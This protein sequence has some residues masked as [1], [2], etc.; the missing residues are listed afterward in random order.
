MPDN[1]LSAIVT[2]ASGQLGRS[3]KDRVPDGV[4]LHMFSRDEF[5][6]SDPVHIDRVFKQYDFDFLINCAAFTGVDLAESIPQEAYRI[7]A[8]AV[9]HLADACRHYDKTLIHISSDYVYDNDITRPLIE[10][11]RTEPKSVYAKSKLEGDR[12][13]VENCPKAIVLRTSW[14][15][16]EYGK[17]FANTMLRLGRERQE[18]RVVADQHGIPTYASDLA[19]AIY[20]IIQSEPGSF[21][22]GIYHFSNTGATTW[23]DF[24]GEILRKSGL[25]TSV[26][27]IDTT[28]FPTPASRPMYSVLDPTKFSKQFSFEIRHWH[29]ALDACLTQI[30]LKSNTDN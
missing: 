18:L 17:N 19:N 27:P 4:T 16:S 30:A 26:V 24:A 21:D 14:L 6:I 5:D 3:L 22:Y 9:K 2:G 8:D 29:D 13:A 15:Y 12:N 25:D 11:D 28:E 10:T 1:N 7:N 23:Y 20:R